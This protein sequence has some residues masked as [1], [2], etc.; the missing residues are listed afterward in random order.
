M[1]VIARYILREYAREEGKSFL[2]IAPQVAELFTSLP[3]PGNVRQL[4]HEIHRAVLLADGDTISADNIL[5]GAR[6]AEGPPPVPPTD[7]EL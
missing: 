6:P 1:N 4:R 2:D 3:W 5:E 7:D